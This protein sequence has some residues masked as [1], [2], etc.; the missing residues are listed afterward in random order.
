MYTIK[1]KDNPL[2]G[3]FELIIP[4]DM[5]HMMDLTSGPNFEPKFTISDDTRDKAEYV[6]S[7]IEGIKYNSDKYQQNLEKERKKKEYWENL[8]RKMREM[9]LSPNEQELI[10]QEALHKEAA[11]Y[12]ETYNM[13]DLDE[14]N[15]PRAILN[16]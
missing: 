12:R 7:Y 14:K 11:L 13:C 4:Q 5:M 1:Y 3:L 6:K 2:I 16:R 8:M 15:T 10:R 9:N